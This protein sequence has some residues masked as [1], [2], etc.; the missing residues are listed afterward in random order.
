MTYRLTEEKLC[1]T[2]VKKKIKK[3]FTSKKSV[4]NLRFKINSKFNAMKDVIVN[5]VATRGRSVC[6]KWKMNFTFI[7][8][9]ETRNNFKWLYLF[10]FQ[11]WSRRENRLKFKNIF[12][13]IKTHKKIS[14]QQWMFTKQKTT[15]S[16]NKSN[17]W[18]Y[19]NKPLVNQNNVNG[20]RKFQHD[21]VKT[22]N[23]A[24]LQYLTNE[25]FCYLSVC[26]NIG[27]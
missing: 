14:I 25:K 17:C 22:I 11:W 18:K 5:R 24:R 20:Y 3:T 8:K 13:N 27:I 23:I 19:P 15:D 16:T 1:F 21:S 4:F 6:T 12:R 26:K 10:S 9:L 7:K 2:V